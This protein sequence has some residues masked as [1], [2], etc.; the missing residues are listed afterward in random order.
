MYFHKNVSSLFLVNVK[1]R[2]VQFLGGTIDFMKKCD[3]L[4]NI[5]I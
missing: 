4:S 1:A 2:P 5:K 3:M